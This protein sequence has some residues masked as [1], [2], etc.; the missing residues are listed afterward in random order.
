MIWQRL[1]A[2]TQR[3]VVLTDALI[4]IAWAVTLTWVSAVESLEFEFHEP[5]GLW[6]FA[7]A[8]GVYCLPLIWRRVFPDHVGLA[9]VLLYVGHRLVL[10]LDAW[11]T[12][13]TSPVVALIGLYSLG[14]Y[15]AN[16]WRRWWQVGA[17]ASGVAFFAVTPQV[18]AEL[19]AESVL[20]AATGIVVVS[21]VAFAAWS[22]GALKHRHM[23]VAQQWSD[24]AALAA[25]EQAASVQA[26]VLVERAR[27]ARDMHD[28]IAH[29]LSV[30]V[31][32]ADGAAF[33]LEHGS[34][35]DQ[36]RAAQ[37]FSALQHIQQAAHTALA[38][39]TQFAQ[40]TDKT[41]NAEPHVGIG[42]IP[43]LVAI[44]RGA[45]YEVHCDCVAATEADLRVGPAVQ[46]VAYRV[47]QEAT[48]N[49]MKHA[50]VNVSVSVVVRFADDVLVCEVADDGRGPG[51]GDGAGSGLLGMAERAVEVGGSVQHGRGAGGG[52]V[53]TAR[54]PVLAV[55]VSDANEVG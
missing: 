22:L 36:E 19:L 42:D 48:T 27:I 2:W 43:Q 9:L 6:R 29:S 14:A 13:V 7:L 52:F 21:G 24:R 11:L 31:V 45:G 37:A 10:P 20:G 44:L 50:G 8:H 38:Q 23:A 25:A 3:H 15:G 40:V 33:A 1:H 32:Q 34:G 55:E 46:E 51:G 18:G 26:S 5:P 28:V 41:L 30:V 12:L 49:V 17:L 47:V 39:S 54:L 4:A 16:R 53:V 35:D